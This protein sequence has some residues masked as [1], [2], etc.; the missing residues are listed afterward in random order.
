MPAARCRETALSSGLTPKQLGKS[1]L[2]PA[3]LRLAAVLTPCSHAVVHETLDVM[4]RPTAS[5]GGLFQML[6][7]QAAICTSTSASLH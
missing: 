6:R 3:E 2:M 4:A 1:I 5:P 7:V